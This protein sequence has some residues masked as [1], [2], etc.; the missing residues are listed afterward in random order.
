MSY[1]QFVGQTAIN[2]AGMLIAFA[3]A[4][5]SPIFL[6]CI[7]LGD[8][9]RDMPELYHRYSSRSRFPSD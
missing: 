8:R 4:A 7:R 3:N 5:L 9:S 1:V 2:M 6:G